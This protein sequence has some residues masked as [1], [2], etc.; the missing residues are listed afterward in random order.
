MDLRGKKLGQYELREQL[1]QGGMAQVYKA[2]QPGMER[3]VAVKVMLGHLATDEEFVERFRREARA[4]G[5]L[6]HPHIVNVFDFGIEDKSYYMVMEFIKG[7]NL[8]AYIGDHPQGL[9]VDEALRIASQIASAL[10][11]AHNAG[12]I[13]RDVKPANIMF[14]DENHRDTVLTDFGIAHILSQPGLTASGAMVG[15]PAYL[16]PDAAYGKTVNERADIYGLGIILYEMLTGRVPYNADTPMAIIMKHVNAPLPSRADFGRDIPESVEAIVLKAM[17]KNADDRYQSAAEMQA[18]LDAARAQLADTKVSGPTK[19]VAAPPPAAVAPAT[20]TTSGPTTVMTTKPATPWPWLIGGV[21]LAALALI[22][23]L[24]VVLG[25]ANDQSTP[26]PTDVPATQIASSVETAED[27]PTEAEPTDVPATATLPPTDVP[28]TA[29]TAAIETPPAVA[30]VPDTLRN[31]NLLSGLNPLQDEID[32]LILEDELELAAERIETTLQSDPQNIEALI[33]RSLLALWNG[34][35]D[36]GR[37]DAE[38]VI[39]LAPDSAW[40]YIAQ[41]DVLSYWSVQDWEGSLA[42]AETALKLDPGNPQILWRL[43]RAQDWVRSPSVAR[44][45]FQQAVDAGASGFRFV[46]YAGEHLYYLGEYEQAVPYLQSWYEFEPFDYSMTLLTGALVQLGR[47]DAAY[48]AVQ[49]FPFALIEPG[50]LRTAAFAAFKAGEYDAAREWAETASALT[51]EDS[52]GAYILGLVSWYGDHNLEQSLR[53]LDEVPVEEFYDDLLSPDFGHEV[54]LD[55]GHILADAGEFEAAIGAY[56]DSLGSLG[57]FPGTYEA[58]ANAHLALGEPQAAL[59]N[60]RLALNVTYDDDPA[61]QQHLTTRIREVARDVDALDNVPEVNLDLLS[62]LGELQDELDTLYIQGDFDAIR[63]RITSILADIPD[64]VGTLTAQSLFQTLN[65]NPRLASR[66]AS[67]IIRIDPGSSLGYIALSEAQ[68]HWKLNNFRAALEAAERALV[69]DPD[70]PEALWRAAE[71]HANLGNWDTFIDL[72]DRA[73]EKGARGFRFIQHAGEYLYYRGEYER[74]LPYLETWHAYRPTEESLGFLTG[75]LIQLDEVDAAYEIV[76]NYPDEIDEVRELVWSAY[77]AYAAE[78]DEQATIWAERA[79]NEFPDALNAQYMLGLLRWYADA[80][81]AGALSYLDPLA[82]N[83]DLWG[84][85]LNPDFEHQVNYD[86]G[87]IL[88]EAGETEAAIE[89]FEYSLEQD[90]RWYT[91][92]GLAEAYLELGD[93]DAARDNIGLALDMTDDEDIRADL[94]AWLEELG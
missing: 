11:Y 85:F 63:E 65:D 74:A 86:R 87:L 52:S 73:I 20:T 60:L 33:A 7:E 68:L 27:A 25:G 40:G 2:F 41:S 51:D 29:T 4:V 18:A 42:A 54:N 36:S 39:E 80:D 32:A 84:V 10:D 69:V 45:N 82:D 22:V 5:Q 93:V 13:H 50:E 71:A 34:D 48:R 49:D 23:V 57:E 12:M 55:R 35:A 75:S 28:A 94:E 56:H 53:F 61:L 79:V 62:G 43:S 24:A 77:V 16:S 89:A 81:L 8:K 91:Y 59:E 66:I 64:D 26:L 21:I 9:P 72:Q 14:V 92:A 37:D 19:A 90:A 30:S 6:R 70:N 58:I 88:L 38:Q 46:I 15:T 3:F 67:D 31:A 78:D 1:G 47:P 83:T 17:Q 44:D 76:Q